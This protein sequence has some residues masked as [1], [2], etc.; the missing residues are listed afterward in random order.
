[1]SGAEFLFFRIILA[2]ITAT[3]WICAGFVLSY[4]KSVFG[5]FWGFV[6]FGVGLVAYGLPLL[7]HL[8]RFGYMFL[9]TYF[10]SYGTFEDLVE[11]STWFSN[12][13]RAAS[14]SSRSLSRPAATP[15]T[16]TNSGSSVPHTTSVAV[17]ASRSQQMSTH[18]PSCR[19]TTKHI[20]AQK[21]NW[22][23]KFN[24]SKCGNESYHKGLLG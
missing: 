6:V 2:P 22:S 16:R 23:G 7:L 18:C 4:L 24:C 13:G 10:D 17:M 3:W 21:E 19:K 11:D 9:T 12:G 1:M 5:S 8:L 20:P 15:N 14:T